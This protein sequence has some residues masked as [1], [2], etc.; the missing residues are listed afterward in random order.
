MKYDNKP[1][2]IIMYKANLHV[3]HCIQQ[4]ANEILCNASYNIIQGHRDD[5]GQ[6]HDSSKEWP[7][8]SFP[9]THKNMPLNTSNLSVMVTN[10]SKESLIVCHCLAPELY[11]LYVTIILFPFVFHNGNIYIELYH[12]H[13]IH[14]QTFSQVTK[15]LHPK[16]VLLISIALDNKVVQTNQTWQLL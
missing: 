16:W 9:K 15:H 3:M 4:D 6:C 2:K 11:L 1:S 8:G 5:N 13:N 7:Y 10:N 12:L 14:W